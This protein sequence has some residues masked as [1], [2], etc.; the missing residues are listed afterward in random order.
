MFFLLSRD[1]FC[2]RTNTM[3]LRRWGITIARGPRAPTCSNAYFAALLNRWKIFEA[4]IIFYIKIKLLSSSFQ[5][6]ST[7]GL[8]I[9]IFVARTDFSPIFHYTYP[10][11]THKRTLIFNCHRFWRRHRRRCWSSCLIIYFIT[12]FR[13]GIKCSSVTVAI[14]GRTTISLETDETSLLPS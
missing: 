14:I 9:I 1:G 7:P 12:F 8:I 6:I 3:L 11:V 2:W 5:K 13:F 4:E 10:I